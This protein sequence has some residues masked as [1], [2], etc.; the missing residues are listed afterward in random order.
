MKRGK[1]WS[2]ALFNAGANRAARDAPASASARCTVWGQSIAR[3]PHATA[4][5]PDEIPRPAAAI[6]QLSNSCAS[7]S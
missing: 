7:R 4:A 1:A 2:P 6:V 5:R 3:R